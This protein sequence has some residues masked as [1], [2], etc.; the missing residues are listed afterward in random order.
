MTTPRP[1]RT[2]VRW[3]LAV[4]APGELVLMLCLASGIRVTPAARTAL[5]LAVLTVMVAATTLLALDYHRH[6]LDGLPRRPALLAAVADTVPAP[7][8]KLAAHEISLTTSFVRW[9]TRRGPH[10]VREGDAAVPY[11]SGQT[12]VMYGFLFV[13]VVETVALAYLIPWPVL[14]TLTLV[15]DV[16]GVYFIIALHASCVVRPHVVGADGSLRLRYGALLDIRIPARH[17]ASARVERRF[18]EGRP[19]AVDA[20]GGADL[21]VA[22]Q[23]TVTV[24]LT[25]P[26]T[27]VRPL[28]KTA[29]ARTFR[30]YAQ[31][32]A[33]AVAALRAR[34]VRGQRSR[35]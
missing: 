7:V 29:K 11:A 15:L 31:D 24:E 5:E 9:T 2:A 35:A 10:G 1:L 20:H 14:H 26:I 18:P 22:G 33:S 27:F 28:G 25:E 21:A 17:I 32:P 23:T 4:L 34:T 12:A 13:S 16:W 3:S 19:A 8:R 6:R 30:Y